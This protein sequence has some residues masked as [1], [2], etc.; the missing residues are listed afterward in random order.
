MVNVDVADIRL[1][2]ETQPDLFSPK[3][4]DTGSRLLLETIIKQNTPYQSI[5]DWGCGWGAIGLVLAAQFG[6]A[7]V[8][9][10]DSDIAA[11]ATTKENVA[12]NKLTNIEV[13]ASHGFSEIAEQQFGLIV[14]N[15]PTHR[16][17]EV[18]DNMIRQSYEHL[19][20]NGVLAIVVE[21]R[22]KPW[23]ARQMKLV[24]GNYKIAQRGP[25]HVIL[26][27]KKPE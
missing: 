10:V 3:G 14:S 1:R 9:A 8:V 25:K 13:I 7:K 24:F 17:R 23:V 15:P 18:V 26:I 6:S 19:D 27:A 5:L 22:L 11:I 12:I 20:T 16:G 4:L 21:A 2:C